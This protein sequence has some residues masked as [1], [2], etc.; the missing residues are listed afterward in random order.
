MLR[1]LFLIG[2][3]TI[4]LQLK[5]HSPN[6]SP[7]PVKPRSSLP[8][9][10][11]TRSLGDKLILARVLKLMYKSTITTN[12]VNTEGLDSVFRWLRYGKLIFFYSMES[13]SRKLTVYSL[14]N[15]MAFSSQ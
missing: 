7:L 13:G 5:N 3:P 15:L 2:F 10:T 9:D 14:N 11:K 4:L 8:L 1:P 6:L 12:S